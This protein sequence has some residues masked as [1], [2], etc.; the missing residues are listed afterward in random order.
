MDTE[1]SKTLDFFWLID[2]NT[3][4]LDDRHSSKSTL[5]IKPGTLEGGRVYT[6]TLIVS[7]RDDPTITTN[8]D[9]QVEV[10][11]SPLVAKIK[12]E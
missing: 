9:V 11:G 1:A 12:G 2:D 6:L 4:I 10:V 5:Y 3:V 7:L 8:I